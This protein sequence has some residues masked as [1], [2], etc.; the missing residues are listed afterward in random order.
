MKKWIFITTC[1][2]G[3][4]LSAVNVYNAQGAWNTLSGGLKQECYFS[5]KMR[6]YV[7]MREYADRS[8]CFQPSWWPLPNRNRQ[9]HRYADASRIPDALWRFPQPQYRHS[10]WR[11]RRNHE[12]IGPLRWRRN[13][14]EGCSSPR[15]PARR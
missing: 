5:E 13:T 8:R 6:N 10:Q 12:R 14:R 4:L 1:T 2:V 3:V 11:A 7:E 15:P 9:E